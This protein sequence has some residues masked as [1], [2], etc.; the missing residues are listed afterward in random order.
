[1]FT[2]DGAEYRK[3]YGNDASLDEMK[4]FVEAHFEE[5]ANKRN[6]LVIRQNLTRIFTI[7]TVRAPN[8]P[9]DTTHK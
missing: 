9:M 5:F 7:M 4:R 1:M 2:R 3:Q 8:P 6:S